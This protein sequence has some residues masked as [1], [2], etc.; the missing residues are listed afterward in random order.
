VKDGADLLASVTHS[1]MEDVISRSDCK[2]TPDA[3]EC[4]KLNYGPWPQIYSRDGNLGFRIGHD[5]E[6][7]DLSTVEMTKISEGFDREEVIE[8]KEDYSVHQQRI[9]LVS[10]LSCHSLCMKY[11]HISR[12]LIPLFQTLQIG[13]LI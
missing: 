11:L 9:Q 10:Q 7:M 12:Q 8:D 4:D 1:R 2:S 6:R 3:F 13:H 5:W